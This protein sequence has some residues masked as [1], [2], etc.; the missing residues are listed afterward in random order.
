MS[1][2]FVRASKYR[3]VFGTPNKRE[4][5]FDNIKISKNAWDTNLVKANPLFLSIN[6]EAGGGG[7]FAVF[8][9]ENTGKLGEGAPCINGHTG[10]V[11]DTDFH[12]F[13]DYII[14]SASEDCT[15]K[16]WRIPVGGLTENISTPLCS[17]TSHSRK[18]D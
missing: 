10:N 11:L 6:L 9:H 12:P 3:H 4:N 17:L 14:A 5:C 2:R 16:L 1:S 7:S 18:V 13:N 8:A 15:V